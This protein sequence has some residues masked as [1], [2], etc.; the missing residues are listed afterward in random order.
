MAAFA[1]IAT[2][3]FWAF[4]YVMIFRALYSEASHF[5]PISLTQTL[6]FLWLGQSMMPLLPFRLDKEIET[7]IRSGQVAY[8]L[9]RPIDLYGVFFARSL[10]FRCIPVL[11]RSCPLWAIAGWFFQLQ[12]PSSFTS[13][14]GFVLS[15]GGAIVLSSAIT[16]LI[17]ITLFWTISGDGIKRLI[18]PISSLL[19][20]ILLPLPLF[21][22]WMQS[23]LSWQPFRGLID[24]PCRI[25]TGM[26]AAENVVFFLAFQIFWTGVFVWM[27]RTLLKKFIRRIAIQGG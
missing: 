20:G 16:T 4:I 6:S 25:Y 1:G 2:Q 8:E 26:I 11:L 5:E 22:E 9:L 23:F 10:A 7:Q 3:I 12:A 17:S 24:I 19:S 15:F 27:G 18:L 21:P 13:L 14:I